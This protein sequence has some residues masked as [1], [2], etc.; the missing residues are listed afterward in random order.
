MQLVIVKLP[1]VV[2][3]FKLSC[4]LELAAKKHPTVPSATAHALATGPLRLL[5][6]IQQLHLFCR[7]KGWLADP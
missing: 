4:L 6:V 5:Q 7:G 2:H 3:H 1:A